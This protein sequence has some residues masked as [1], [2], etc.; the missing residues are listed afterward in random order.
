MPEGS[1]AIVRLR[2]K[3]ELIEFLKTCKEK[4]AQ[5]PPWLRG[6]LET[7]NEAFNQDM[8][9][10]V[11]PIDKEKEQLQ[12]LRKEVQKV[13]REEP[14]DGYD[15]Q[16]LVDFRDWVWVMFLPWKR[17]DWCV[18]D[19]VERVRRHLVENV[20]AKKPEYLDENEKQINSKIS[21][22]PTREEII[23]LGEQAK[24]EIASWPKW[25]QQAV[26]EALNDFPF[27]DTPRN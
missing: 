11:E 17:V 4:V 14:I 5:Q 6:Y 1:R 27:R 25:R 3:P 22:A 24:K 16:E 23:A 10:P 13:W 20:K 8:R 19:L 12:Q 18:E 2:P 15:N 7:S 9:E 21:T 26:K